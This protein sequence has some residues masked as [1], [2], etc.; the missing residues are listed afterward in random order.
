MELFRV[1]NKIELSKPISEMNKLIEILQDSSQNL[2]SD[3]NYDIDHFNNDTEFVIKAKTTT[4]ADFTPVSVR[5]LPNELTVTSWVSLDNF[6]I[7]IMSIIAS[8]LL[9]IYGEVSIL[10]KSLVSI[11]FI[12][13]SMLY[14][15]YLSHS[16]NR[17]IRN[18]IHQQLSSNR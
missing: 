2:F 9:F 18:K 4:I 7:V 15:L 1:E 11:L 5:L 17:T 6:R 14:L 8:V 12:A 10:T 16:S 3:S 13:G